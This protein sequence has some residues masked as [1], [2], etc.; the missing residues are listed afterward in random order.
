VRILVV[1]V[2]GTNLKISIGPRR[3][4]TKVPSGP[5]MTAAQ[6]A[7]AVKE[8]VGDRTYDAVSIGYP[9]PVV[10]GR[11]S[12]EPKNLGGGWI[13]FDYKTAFGKPVRVVNDAVMQAL[14]SYEGGRMLFLGLGTGLGSSLVLDGLVAPLEI[15]HLPYHEGGTYED[16]VGL[17]GY[18]RMGPKRWEKH[19]ENVV[20][21]LKQALQ[22]D[23]VMLGG[24]QSRK[25]EGLPAGARLGTNK[26]AILGGV[27]LWSRRHRRNRFPQVS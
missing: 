25:L 26:H 5:A 19:V 7:A 9:G 23:Y 12:L 22:V 1:D 24:G 13:R 3:K 18:K 4:A 27:R 17:R 2:G 20:A 11:P 21:I 14:G 10:D 6:M 8:C 16:Y 15:A